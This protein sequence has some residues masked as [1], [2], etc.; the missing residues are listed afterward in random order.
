[1]KNDSKQSATRSYSIAALIVALIACIVT[2]FLGIV[3]GLTSAQVVTVA[4]VDNLQRYLYVSAGFI[5]L[6]LATYA[7]LEPERVRRFLTGRQAR[8]G[9]N[10]F[11]M[12][13][14]FAGILIIGNV[15]AYQNPIPLADLTDGPMGCCAHRTPHV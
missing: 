1:M 6:G 4:N 15:L 9:S 8:Y 14:A 2:F 13:I 5:V 11:I 12:S 10:A 3:R 7:I